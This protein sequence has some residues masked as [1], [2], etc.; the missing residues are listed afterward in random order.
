MAIPQWILTPTI[1]CYSRRATRRDYLRPGAIA[2]LS[3]IMPSVRIRRAA[4]VGFGNGFQILLEAGLLPGAML[5][6]RSW[7]VCRLE[8]RSGVYEVGSAV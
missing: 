5:I 1:A 7:Y 4:G 8:D 6:N 3:P 2:K